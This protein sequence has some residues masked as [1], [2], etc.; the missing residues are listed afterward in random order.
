MEPPGG[1][2]RAD[3]VR[4]ESAACWTSLPEVRVGPGPWGVPSLGRG[5]RCA[6]RLK[7]GPALPPAPCRPSTQ[8]AG[9]RPGHGHAWRCPSP[10]TEPCAS[11]GQGRWAGPRVRLL[12]AAFS[13][14]PPGAS[15]RTRLRCGALPLTCQPEP[16]RVCVGDAGTAVRPHACF[17]ADP[18]SRRRCVPFT[19]LTLR[20]SCGASPGPA[21]CLASPP[22][23]LCRGQH[24]L[25]LATGVRHVVIAAVRV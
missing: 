3:A 15:R 23:C 7:S 13:R 12:Q 8:M 2:G 19:A 24:A 20:L 9:H 16:R 4:L 14:A 1:A 6:R 22:V 17:S 10:P 18:A 25:P 21:A 5:Q 11:C